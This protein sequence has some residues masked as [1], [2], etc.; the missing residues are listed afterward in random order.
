MA[1]HAPSLSSVAPKI[2]PQFSVPLSALVL[3]GQDNAR[4]SNTI[5]TDGIAQMASMLASAGQLYPLIVSK[6]EDN[7]FTVHAGQRRTRGFAL[8]QQQGLIK[9]DHPVDVRQVAAED[10]FNASLM[11]NISQ[12]PMPP[13]D[14]FCAFKR[15]A[16]K[17][18]TPEQISKTYGC[19]ALH[20][21]R[22]MKLAGVHPELLAQFR[23]G[24]I[25]LD[26][27]MALASCDDQEEQLMVWEGLPAWRRS[28]QQIRQQ[29][30]EN[31]VAIDDDRVKLV[32]VD[33]YIAAGGQVRKDL[34]SEE[35]NDQQLTDVGLLDLMVAERLEAAAEQLRGE[36][37]AWVEVLSSFGYEERQLYPA[38]PTQYLPENDEQK[39]RSAD[40]KIKISTLEEEI[41]ELEDSDDEA[42]AIKLE[43][44]EAE[45]AQLEGAQES[46]KN[47]LIDLN[48]LDMLIAGAVVHTRGGQIVIEKPLLKAADLNQ[49]RAKRSAAD[50]AGAVDGEEGNKE[51][52]EAL[53][54]RLMRNLTAQRTGAIQ[55]SMLSNQ[56]VA[57]ACLAA[58]MAVREFGKASWSDSSVKISITSQW[59][60]LRDACPTFQDSRAYRELLAACDAWSTQLPAEP[61]EYLGWFLA[62]PLQVSLDMITFAAATSI[63][64]IRGRP[65]SADTAAALAAALGLDMRQWWSPTSQDYLSLVPKAKMIQAVVEAHGGPLAATGWEK[66]KKAEVLDLAH[67]SLRGTGWLPAPLR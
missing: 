17:G 24:E 25:R 32:G 48:G 35:G 15:L 1:K 9:A 27:I 34:F 55:A 30:A 3:S 36:G 7:T 16:D 61:A 59:L 54:E 38:Y 66:L 52:V 56:S 29:L 57:L 42:D 28:D 8:L 63:D 10:G 53:S 4:S 60:T 41:S 31:E 33:A 67:D 6:R 62:Q 37:W 18:N 40:L 65:E 26:Q 64:A 12:E 43:A 22:R 46:L 58:H 47:E 51:P 2:S 50:K 44:K 20:V 14:E 21:K 13:A 5:S 11:E 45:L 23:S 19:T 49:I 39:M